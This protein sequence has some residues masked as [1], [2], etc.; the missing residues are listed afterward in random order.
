MFWKF[1]KS[2]GVMLDCQ[3]FTNK[4]CSPWWMDDQVAA[5]RAATCENVWRKSSLTGKAYGN[6]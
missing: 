6:H 4:F 5:E 2:F 3:V 1:N